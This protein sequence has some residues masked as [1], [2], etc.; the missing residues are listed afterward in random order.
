ML[1]HEDSKQTTVMDT[2]VGDG[3]TWNDKKVTKDGPFDSKT[4]I[5]IEQRC[6]RTCKTKKNQQ[7]VNN[8]E[9]PVNVRVSKIDIN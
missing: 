8:D 2:D 3:L 5:G 9:G 6:D 7:V 1:I 4:R